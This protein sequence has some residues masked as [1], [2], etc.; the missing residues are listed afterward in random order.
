MTNRSEFIIGTL[1]EVNNHSLQEWRDRTIQERLDIFVELMSVWQPN[2]K[3]IVRTACLV[4][5]PR[6]S[7]GETDAA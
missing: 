3:G 4:E 6:S 5:V 7:N 2:A 1:A